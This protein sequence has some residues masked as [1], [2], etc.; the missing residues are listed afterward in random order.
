MQYTIKKEFFKQE[1]DILNAAINAGHV[2]GY[3]YTREGD[4]V[5]FVVIVANC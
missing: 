4:Q 1:I 3:N 2:Y 5:R